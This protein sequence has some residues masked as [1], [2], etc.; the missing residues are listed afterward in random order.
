MPSVN[1]PS[2]YEP[3][4]GAVTQAIEAWASW[5]TTIGSQFGLININVGA[6]SNPATERSVVTDVAGY[7]KQLGRVEDA[8]LVLMKHAKLPANLPKDQK[9]AI[10]DLNSMLNEIANV[11]EQ[12]GAKNVLRPYD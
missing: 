8:L 11:R 12:N 9:R 3:F 2:V 5:F 1:M 4:S 7:G 10:D 6:S